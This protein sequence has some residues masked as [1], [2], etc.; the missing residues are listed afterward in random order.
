MVLLGS[1][2]ASPLLTGLDVD[3]VRGPTHTDPHRETGPPRAEHCA[4]RHDAVRGGSWMDPERR[5]LVVP[6]SP[7]E[8]SG[9]SWSVM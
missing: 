6:A 4:N 8:T 1:R 9:S 2:E 7:L 3:A 5:I